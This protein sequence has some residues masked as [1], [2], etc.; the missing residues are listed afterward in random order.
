MIFANRKSEHER[1]QKCNSKQAHDEIFH[2]KLRLEI[3]FMETGL[4]SYADLLADSEEIWIT[5]GWYQEI[6]TEVLTNF[7]LGGVLIKISY[8]KA[9]PRGSNH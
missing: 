5:V 1:H 3:R 9:P 8:G 7:K 4:H 6:F 2:G